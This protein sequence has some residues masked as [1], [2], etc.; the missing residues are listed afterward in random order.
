M[1]ALATTICQAGSGGD[2]LSAVTGLT[3]NRDASTGDDVFGG[4]GGI[5]ISSVAP[6]H[7]PVATRADQITSGLAATRYLAAPV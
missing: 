7:F 6:T 2:Q 1:A 5:F 3:R 4:I